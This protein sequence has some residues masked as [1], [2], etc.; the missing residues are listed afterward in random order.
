MSEALIEERFEDFGQGFVSM[1]PALRALEE[2]LLNTRL[3]HGMHPVLTSC[4]AN[5]VVKMDEAGN[6][7]FDKKRSTG[8]I[9]GA[10]S[11]A[12][13]MATAAE[14][15]HRPAVYGDVALESLLEDMAVAQ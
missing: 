7:K 9:D 13:A 8:R 11:L 5:A 3:R 15:M 10:V 6:R 1:S 4:M 12:M 14:D 2:N